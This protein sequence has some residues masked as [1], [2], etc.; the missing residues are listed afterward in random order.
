MHLEKYRFLTKTSGNQESCDSVCFETNVKGMQSFLRFFFK[1]GYWFTD[2]NKRHSSIDRYLGCFYI[3][4][5]VN[6]A[7]M[8]MGIH[9]SVQDSDFISVRYVTKSGID[10]WHVVLFLSFWGPSILL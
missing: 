9:I 10:R 6:N 1:R 2:M 4:P 7:A 5:I 8:N 3:L